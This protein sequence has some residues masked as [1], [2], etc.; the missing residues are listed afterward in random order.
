MSYGKGS[1]MDAIPIH[2]DIT[3]NYKRI[4]NLSQRIWPKGNTTFHFESLLEQCPIGQGALDAT[5]WGYYI[6]LNTFIKKPT[7]WLSH[8]FDVIIVCIDVMKLITTCW[9]SNRKWNHS[10]NHEKM[11]LP[12][13]RHIKIHIHCKFT[14][15]TNN[16]NRH[17]LNYKFGM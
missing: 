10:L 8:W 15:S 13:K 11:I 6:I 9:T 17:C 7:F 4:V 2:V 14:Y 5:N 16:H 3:S 12:C 1:K